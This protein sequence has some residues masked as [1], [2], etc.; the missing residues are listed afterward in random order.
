[1]APRHTWY[2]GVYSYA[3]LDRVYFNAADVVA[4]GH[5]RGLDLRDRDASDRLNAVGLVG[6]KGVKRIGIQAFL[7][8][9]NRSSLTGNDVLWNEMFGLNPAATW[10]Y[11]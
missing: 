3:T 11:W 10:R 5:L 8:G 4:Y 1:M 9:F 6:S 2:T 7:H